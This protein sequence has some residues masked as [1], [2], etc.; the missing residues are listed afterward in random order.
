[1]QYLKE[2]GIIKSVNKDN[3]ITVV[4]NPTLKKQ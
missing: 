4:I 3:N 1:M 2:K